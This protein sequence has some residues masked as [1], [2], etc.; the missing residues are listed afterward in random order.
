VR[1]GLTLVAGVLVGNILGFGRVALTA[2]LLGT[3]SFADTLAV[4]MGPVD[5]F[6]SVLINSLVFA[7]VPM[8]TAL[9]GPE[10]AALARR[11]AGTFTWALL[12]I[13]AVTVAAAPW[14]MKALAPG[15]RQPFFDLAVNNLRIMAC[16][17]AASG[18]GAVFCAVL[19]T[20]RRF[21]P[22]AFYQA[23]L[24]LCTICGALLFWKLWGVYAFASGYAAGAWVQLGIV[25][26][27]ARRSLQKDASA[28]CGVRRRD[29]FTRPAMYMVYAAALALNM[30]F[31]RAW[32]TQ[33]GPGMAA[34]LDYCLRGVGVPL[35]ILVI[36]IS[37]T[38]LPEIAR[39]RS[40]G[41][42]R[43]ALRLLDRAT[44]ATGAIAIAGCVF[45][46]IFRKP[47][48]ALL[49]QRGSFTTESTLLV[50]AVFVG[51]APS[52]IGWSLIEIASRG[53]FALER[54]RP[55]VIAAIIPV[56]VNA[57]VTIGIRSWRPELVGLGATLG[58]FAGF[59]ALFTLTHTTRKQWAEQLP[60][61]TEPNQG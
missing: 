32:A 47:V 43:V 57:A 39:L 1:G 35:A 49:F 10:R 14:F 50:S 48:I 45:A 54:S 17:I 4:A 23:A 27:A 12:A 26:L 20:E 55:P 31:T 22:T 3:H 29:I 28:T 56:L 13:T 52:L 2:Y 5:A 33:A 42:I 19:Y 46:L 7:F 59:A 61:G 40:A 18:L 38:L 6:N 11:L 53:L 36:P 51:L 58:L 30:T 25:G 21:G 15:L 16:S 60:A 34:A 41:K 24:N 9:K 37:N 8:L 44:L